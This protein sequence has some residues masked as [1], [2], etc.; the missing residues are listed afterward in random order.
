M[1]HINLNTI[2][3]TH[4]ERS[5]TKTIYTKIWKNNDTG[6][7]HNEF[8]DITDLCACAH[9]PPPPTFIYACTHV[10][11]H[12][13]WLA[14]T[15]YWYWLG[16]KYCEKRK[17]FSLALKDDRVE[18]CLRSCGTE[19]QMCGLKQEKVQMPWVLRVNVAWVGGWG[20]GETHNGTNSSTGLHPSFM[21]ESAGK[22]CS[23]CD[24]GT[25]GLEWLPTAVVARLIYHWRSAA[26]LLQWAS[27]KRKKKMLQLRSHT[28][29][30]AAHAHTHEH[31]HSHAHAHT[32]TLAH[33]HT[34]THTH[35]RE[36]SEST[37]GYGHSGYRFVSYNDEGD[38]YGA[39][40]SV[41]AQ[42]GVLPNTTRTQK[43]TRQVGRGNRDDFVEDIHSLA[44][45][46]R[47]R[48]PWKTEEGELTE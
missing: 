32:H 27:S 35:C 40:L 20:E 47:R 17:A 26:S 1:I 48:R 6:T 7:N 25:A 10:H 31:T 22:R 16:W 21:E 36:T 23:E 3:Y 42:G 37:R 34:H 15:G 29:L 5:P 28:H 12:T 33:T 24:T 43:H 11:V 14:E 44:V 41:G 9:P 46:K 2:F 45:L 39:P 18:Q 30:R 4:V 13:H 8:R 38:F 19:S